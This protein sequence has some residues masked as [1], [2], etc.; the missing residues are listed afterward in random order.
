VRVLITGASGFLGSAVRSAAAARGHAVTAASRTPPAGAPVGAPASATAASGAAA[1]PGVEWLAA[2]LVEPDAAARLVYAAQPDGVIHCAAMADV[3]PCRTMPA[4]AWRVNADAAG[5]LAAACAAAGSALVHVST[6]L[7]FDGSRGA[8]TEADEARPL[9]VYGATKLAGEQAVAARLPAAAIVRAGLITGRA[10]AGR[11]SGT[12]AFLAA[13][14]RG[15]SP[16][17]FT[18][19]LRSPIAAADVAR[20]L[21]DL[22][23]RLVAGR[24][25]ADPAASGL[26]HC[27]GPEALSRHA[28][29]LREAAAAGLDPRAIAATTRAAAGLSDERPADV[30]LDSRRLLALLRWAPRTLDPAG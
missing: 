2:D 4:L 8:W 25:A 29:A 15:E 24:A 23:E 12:S 5:E 26:F 13:L 18:D 14:A 6:D 27:G 10:P 22:L 20:A 16:R 3:A 17:M 1:L 30:S 9:H 21:L 28:L 11:R 19:E 7:V